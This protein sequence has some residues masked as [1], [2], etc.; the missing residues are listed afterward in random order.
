MNHWNAARAMKWAEFRLGFTFEGGTP[1]HF[2]I[3]MKVKGLRAI[4]NRLKTKDGGV[5][6]LG[7][8]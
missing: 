2:C 5:R 7:G 1:R 6:F 3:G 4:R 8:T